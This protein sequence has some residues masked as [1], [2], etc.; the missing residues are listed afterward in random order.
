MNLVQNDGSIH[1]RLHVV[2]FLH[3]TIVDV[4]HSCGL[5]HLS[6]VLKFAKINHET[7]C[8][9]YF[10]LKQIGRRV[11]CYIEDLEDNTTS[12]IDPILSMHG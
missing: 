6:D 8:G 11:A 4:A 9:P 3:A 1:S 12:Y 5:I 10:F 7:T 2:Y